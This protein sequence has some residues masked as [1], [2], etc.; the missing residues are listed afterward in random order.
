[1]A[2]VLH[3]DTYA[4]TSLLYPTTEIRVRQGESMSKKHNVL[5]VQFT[6]TQHPNLDVAT[7]NV[8]ENMLTFDSNIVGNTDHWVK[9]MVMFVCQIMNGTSNHSCM[10]HLSTD[11][12]R[13][14]SDQ[15]VREYKHY[16]GVCKEL[17]MYM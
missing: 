9:K 3:L 10:L 7:Y 5:R 1:M 15:I 2:R 14:L 11:P 8:S 12:L 6:K 16:D 13:N 17:I 4:I